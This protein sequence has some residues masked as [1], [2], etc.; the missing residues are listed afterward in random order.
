M[1]KRLFISVLVLTGLFFTAKAQ[2][3]KVIDG[4]GAVIV[5][6]MS[7]DGKYV[8]GQIGSTATHLFSWTAEDGIH[9]WDTE[10]INYD[11]KG[12]MA[13]G[14]SKTGRIVGIAPNPDH[15]TSMEVGYEHWVDYYVFTSAFCEYGT[16]TWIY[17]P[18]IFSN[19]LYY[20]YGNSACGITDNGSR[21]VGSQ[22]PGGQAQRKYAGYWDIASLDDITFV[23][24]KEDVGPGSGPG[25]EAVCVSG[26]G[27][28]IGGWD[29]PNWTKIPAI[30]IDD[31][32]TPMTGVT[33]EGCVYG[34]SANG[35]YA[36]LEESWKAGLYKVEEDSFSHLEE[37]SADSKALAVSNDGVVVG[38]WG[39]P[40]FTKA[41]IYTETRGMI[42]LPDFLDEVEVEYPEGFNF[43]VV[44]GIAADGSSIC[45]YGTLN[46]ATV[47]FHAIVGE[48][49]GGLDPVTQISA[50]NNSY[51]AIRVFWEAVPESSELTGYNVYCNDALVEMTTETSFSHTGLSDGSYSYYVKALY[52]SEEALPSKSVKITMGK[53]ALPYYQGFDDCQN[54]APGIPEIPLTSVF[55]D[56]STNTVGEGSGWEVGASGLPVPCALFFSPPGG[57]YRESL[58]SPFFDASGTEDLFL[59][60]NMTDPGFSAGEVME[61]EVFDGE[62]WISVDVITANGSPFS[63]FYPKKYDISQAA[64]KNSVRVRFSCYGTSAGADL[65]WNIDNIE[66]ADSKN[67]AVAEPPLVAGMTAEDGRVFVNWSDN[68]GVAK[69]GYILTNEWTA[70]M[71]GNEGKPFI[72][73]NMYPAEDLKIYEGYKLTS[74]SFMPNK[75]P[76]YYGATATYTWFVMQDETRLF[77]APVEN[78]VS[79]E[80]VTIQ[81]AN[82]IAID[83]SKPLYYGVEVVEHDP[84]D[85]PVATSD[86]YKLEEGPGGMMMYISIDAAGGRGDI[87]S[88]D[89]GQTWGELDSFIDEYGHPVYQLFCI[90]ATLEKEPELPINTRIVGYR[91][92]R[93]GENILAQEFD[94]NE[95]TLISTNTFVDTH[96]LPEGEHVCYEI[97]SYYNLQITSE[98]TSVCTEVNIDKLPADAAFHVFPNPVNKGETIYVTFDSNDQTTRNATIELYNMSGVKVLEKPA[99]GASTPLNL[100]VATGVYLLKVDNKSVKIIVN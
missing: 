56:V 11:G 92:F 5:N 80:W 36:A 29:A 61:I 84:A 33:G 48:V 23:A 3:F 69:L 13:K 67:L 17:P 60:F 40:N 37:G 98:G 71:I 43:Q 100:D 53:A 76:E 82:P 94:D 19:P 45:G 63:G 91:V 20:G 58:T 34:I 85:L 83:A 14:V 47:G 99:A 22:A 89:G 35:K 12:S 72:A 51:G 16:E 39:Y 28:V 30:W 42:E 96:P 74:L 97:M 70:G 79:Q 32:Q 21:I 68:N 55:W 59:R 24:L 95:M 46:G 73:A 93:N 31:V 66:V 49:Q 9:E 8:V 38:G 4:S 77:E 7:S 50:E 26:D 25:S 64:G 88:E 87:Y 65:N 27:S 44:T 86:I 90:R 81:L 75:N 52:G 2:D 78:P 1:K 6:G 57:D 10:S 54:A 18:L 62:E 41:F 15:V